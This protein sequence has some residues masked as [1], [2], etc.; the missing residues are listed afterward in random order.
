MV[1]TG[2]ELARAGLG[3]PIPVVDDLP[4]GRI[5][6]AAPSSRLSCSGPFDALGAVSIDRTGS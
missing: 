4:P 6:H 3:V 5:H 2:A 1:H